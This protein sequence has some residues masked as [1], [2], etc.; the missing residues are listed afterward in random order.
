MSLDQIL[1]LFNPKIN[2]DVHQKLDLMYHP[3]IIK[4]VRER[5]RKLRQSNKSSL[6]KTY[7]N[8]EATGIFNLCSNYYLIKVTYITIDSFIIMN[9]YYLIILVYVSFAIFYLN[10][11]YIV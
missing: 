8:N 10:F 4:S 5:K 7:K 1:F 6:E 11:F 9:S 3:L 2:F